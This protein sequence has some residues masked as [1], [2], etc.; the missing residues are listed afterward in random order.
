MLFFHSPK[1]K[2]AM[3]FPPSVTPLSTMLWSR[4]VMYHDRDTFDFRQGN[5]TNN[6]TKGCPCLVE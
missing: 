1:R 5:V 4:A 6:Q 3:F 2:L